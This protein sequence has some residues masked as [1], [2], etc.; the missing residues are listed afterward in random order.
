MEVTPS[1]EVQNEGAAAA[2]QDA[3]CL[4]RASTDGDQQSDSQL[5]AKISE[6]EAAEL[7]ELTFTEKEKSAAA[8]DSVVVDGGD[9]E[10][11][12]ESGTVEEVAAVADATVADAA[13]EDA[14][15]TDAVVEETVKESVEEIVEEIETAE[16]KVDEAVVVDKSTTG[17]ASDDA[18]T[19]ATAA[20]VAEESLKA[21][22][23]D[24]EIVPESSEVF[25]EEKVAGEIGAEE[26][27]AEESK[28]EAEV[29]E[30]STKEPIK[31]ESD[32]AQAADVSGA[33]AEAQE[34]ADT[35]PTDA[36]YQ[37]ANASFASQQPPMNSDESE[38]ECDVTPRS[39]PPSVVKQDISLEDMVFDGETTIQSD[40]DADVA[41][42]SKAA[43]SSLVFDPFNSLPVMGAKAARKAEEDGAEISETKKV[44]LTEKEDEVITTETPVGLNAIIEA[45]EDAIRQRIIRKTELRKQ[46]ETQCAE[47]S[48]KLKNPD[49][50][51]T[52]KRHIELLKGYNTIRDIGVG[53]LGMARALLNVIA[54][55]RG[56]RVAEVMQEFGLD[57]KD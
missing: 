53:L 38:E 6:G 13:A 41:A 25:T 7:V 28:A 20:A 24:A 39:R 5:L 2:S 4:A 27:V 29:V 1:A 56:V 22:T 46:L 37:S 35:I 11:A 8:T 49:A 17:D 45:K 10:E 44:K 55:T 57:V 19:E 21:K 16:E 43:K 31:Q 3:T 14:I 30:E 33:P 9:A 50:A 34:I 40:I 48:A 32:E 54:D 18:T 42:S 12:E 51:Q 26:S 23:P 36:D 52:I 47:E 15:E